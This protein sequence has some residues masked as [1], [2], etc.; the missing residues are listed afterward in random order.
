MEPQGFR[1]RKKWKMAMLDFTTQSKQVPTHQLRH[2][3][4]GSYLGDRLF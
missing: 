2:L 1:Y 4:W 3:V